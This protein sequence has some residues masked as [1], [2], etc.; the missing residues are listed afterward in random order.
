MKSSEHCFLEIVNSKK[1]RR[2]LMSNEDKLQHLKFKKDMKKD[3]YIYFPN[4]KLYIEIR[5][6]ISQISYLECKIK[7]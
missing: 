2:T 6:L 7:N 1:R 3:Y 4:V 5:E